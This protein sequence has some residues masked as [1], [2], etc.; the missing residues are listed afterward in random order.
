MAHS[1]PWFQQDN[2]LLFTIL[3]KIFAKTPVWSHCR[4]FAD[5]KNGRAVYNAARE[6]TI[7]KDYTSIATKAAVKTIQDAT[8]HGEER[9]WDF[10]KFH[11]KLIE[12]FQILEDFEHAGLHNGL[13]EI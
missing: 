6:Y 13:T 4:G 2:A 3:H 10:A 5:A 11:T 9:N 1:K 7:G 8:Y 12:A